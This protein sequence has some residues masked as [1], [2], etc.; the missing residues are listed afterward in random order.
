MFVIVNLPGV[1]ECRETT[2][3]VSLGKC[4]SYWLSIT[5][6]SITHPYPLMDVFVDQSEVN[7]HQSGFFLLT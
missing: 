4:H 3:E 7:P 6:P 5:H 2:V 1:G